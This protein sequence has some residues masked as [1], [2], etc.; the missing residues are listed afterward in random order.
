MG[1]TLQRGAVGV[2]CL[3]G[4]LSLFLRASDPGVGPGTN[5]GSTATAWWEFLWHISPK[6]SF[7]ATG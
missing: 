3:V 4:V 6:A 5:L 7:G 1:A 2:Q